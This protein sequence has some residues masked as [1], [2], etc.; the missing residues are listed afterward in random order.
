MGKLFSPVF[1][2][3]TFAAKLLMDQTMTE[4]TPSPQPLG[5]QPAIQ[6]DEIVSRQ[7]KLD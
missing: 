3:A 4:Q 6:D 5:T 1:L 7:R 2:F